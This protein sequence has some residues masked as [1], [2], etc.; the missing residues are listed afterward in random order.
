MNKKGGWHRILTSLVVLSALSAK[1]I[2]ARDIPRLLLCIQLD[3][4]ESGLLE[5]YRPLFQKDGVERLLSEGVLYANADYGFPITDS[6][7]ALAT[8]VSGSYPRQHKLGWGTD[9]EALF[10]STAYRGVNTSKNLSPERLSYHTLGDVLEEVSS[11]RS[12]V[13]TLAA[14]APTALTVSSLGASAAFWIDERNGM[15]ASSSYYTKIPKSFTEI[16]RG[17]QSLRNSLVKQ[18]WTPLRKVTSSPLKYYQPHGVQA[19]FHYTF[20]ASSTYQDYITSPLVDDEITRFA[21]ALLRERA[22]AKND[23]PI[24]LNVTYSVAPSRGGIDYG[25]YSPESCDAYLRADHAIASLLRVAEQVYGKEQCLVVLATIP[26]SYVSKAPQKRDVKTK[27]APQGPIYSPAKATALVNLYLSAIYGKDNWVERI[28]S[29][30]VYLNR[31]LIERK[32]LPLD[33]IQF[34]TAAFMREMD[35]VADAFA[36]SEALQSEESALRMWRAIPLSNRADV[37]VRLSAAS[38][39]SESNINNFTKSPM[40][41]ASQPSWLL[42][43]RLGGEGQRVTRPIEMVSLIPTLAYILRIRP[44]TGAEGRPLEEWL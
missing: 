15:W 24:I 9:Y 18:V 33:E 42:I 17:D 27:V 10:R 14:Q 43:A 13:Y 2:D 12:E 21:T 7:S 23:A 22:Q 32:S 30:V 5:S 38:W 3:G 20:S 4:A 11:G 28:T 29:D 1:P 8:L 26:Q 19:D 6:K 44:P 16:N 39:F 35:G 36:P 31:S 40:S 25:P 37:L 41:V 34:R